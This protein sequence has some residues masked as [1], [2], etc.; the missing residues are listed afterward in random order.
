MVGLEYCCEGRLQA[1]P[2]SAWSR[3]GFG[4]PDSTPTLSGVKVSSDGHELKLERFRL[5]LRTHFIPTRTDRQW[6][7]IC[8][9]PI[10]RGFHDPR[11]KALIKPQIKVLVQESPCF[12]GAL[13]AKR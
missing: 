13:R 7:R 8:V 4:A 10:L 3:G 5:E 2:G 11:K 12:C 1:R 6:N 9:I